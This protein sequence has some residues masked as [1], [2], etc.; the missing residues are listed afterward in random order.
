[1]E[2][3]MP[4]SAYRTGIAL[5]LAV[6]LPSC[7][8]NTIRLDR[9]TAMGEAGRA[10]TE[11]TRQVMSEIRSTNRAVLVD[12]VAEDPRCVLPNPVIAF[13]TGS[14]GSKLCRI[15]AQVD[16]DFVM[17]RFIRR[18]FAPSLAVIDGLS[19]YLGAVDA[20]LT[21]KPV[22]LA[23]ELTG[24]E[25]KL[26]SLTNSLSVI[27]GTPT[28]PALTDAQSSAI[29]GTLDLLSDIIDEAKRVDDLKKIELKLDAQKF[30]ANL[31]ALDKINEELVTILNGQL[32][33]QQ[34]LVGLRLRSLSSGTSESRRPVVE[35]QMAMI[36][37]QE[38]LP[39]LRVGLAE[40]V[41]AFRAAH[42]D[43]RDLLF[44][45]N[46]KLTPAE[47]RKAAAITQARVL[48]ALNN[49]ASLIKAF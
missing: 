14:D 32:R 49:L 43:Y 23:A 2:D 9:A 26:R 46:A 20:V 7:A 36:E 47:K 42:K 28:L 18:E 38:N 25:A 33:N 22:D 17:K 13:G 41:A 21:R 40:A 11:G 39:D 1:M 35:Q 37:A 16:G 10:A 12:L 44:D 31:V 6:A 4:Y 24:A 15:T 29:G 45:K 27:A 5:I 8:L 30:E 34:T 48:A 19:A 3:V